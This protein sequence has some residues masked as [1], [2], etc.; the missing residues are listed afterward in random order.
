[1]RGG[2]SA[3]NTKVTS[4]ATPQKPG[5]QVV[6]KVW[7]SAEIAA[8]TGGNF[9]PLGTYKL[10]ANPTNQNPGD[11]GNTM[12]VTG[13]WLAY[14]GSN[15]N[16][17]WNMLF[18][19]KTSSDNIDVWTKITQLAGTR[20]AMITDGNYPTLGQPC[21]YFKLTNDAGTSEVVL[22]NAYTM[23]VPNKNTFSILARKNLAPSGAA[24]GTVVGSAGVH[25]YIGSP[26]TT[27][28]YTLSVAVGSPYVKP[29]T[30]L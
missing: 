29:A 9:F 26:N 4:G 20:T 15:A 19:A 17:T 27:D 25:S 21:F 28:T 10:T 13:T 30:A 2:A 24:L 7:T 14:V 8:N 11:V 12:P 23:P 3:Y 6:P 18:C 16:Q 1:M 5:T 22:R